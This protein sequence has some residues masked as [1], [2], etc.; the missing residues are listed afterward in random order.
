M[1]SEC[2]GQTQQPL[3][4]LTASSPPL[5]LHFKTFHPSLGAQQDGNDHQQAGAGHTH[6][7]SS[8]TPLLSWIPP[9]ATQTHQEIFPD[10]QTEFPI[11][12]FLPIFLT[13]LFSTAGCDSFS[14]FAVHSVTSE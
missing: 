2:V 4:G 3:T 9:P 1:A 12:Q 5:E 14:A 6:W 13:E 11:L 8:E 7:S 10:V